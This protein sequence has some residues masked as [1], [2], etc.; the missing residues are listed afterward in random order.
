VCEATAFESP[1]RHRGHFAWPLKREAFFY[2]GPDEFKLGTLSF[3]CRAVAAEKPIL[4][5]LSAE[6][7]AMLR[8]EPRPDSVDL[9]GDHRSA[10]CPRR[11]IRSASE[12]GFKLQ[13]LR[14]SAGG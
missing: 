7:I 14:R 11:L 4:V 5:V 8:R 3:I 1:P 10:A 2:A 9:D 12:E 6:K 13:G